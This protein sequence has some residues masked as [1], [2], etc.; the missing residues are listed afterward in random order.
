MINE[1][2]IYQITESGSSADTIIKLIE[3]E[4]QM[5]TLTSIFLEVS[6]IILRVETAYRELVQGELLYRLIRVYRD[7]G[8]VLIATSP[9][10][11]HTGRHPQRATLFLLRR[12]LGQYFCILGALRSPP[13][14]R[15][16]IFCFHY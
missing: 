8:S 16:V 11:T 4:L 5:H 3:L 9:Q 13:V 1:C 6:R 7:T 10:G 15:G 2:D 14:Q 12:K